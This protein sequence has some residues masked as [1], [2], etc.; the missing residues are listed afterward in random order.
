M[1]LFGEGKRLKVD[2][3]GLNGEAMKFPCYD[4]ECDILSFTKKIEYHIFPTLVKK[5]KG[6]TSE[7]K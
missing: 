4:S 1:S 6:K 5:L 3:G 2:D 7:S